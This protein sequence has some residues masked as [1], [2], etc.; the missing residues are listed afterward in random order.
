VQREIAA[1]LQR[2]SGAVDQASRERDRLRRRLDAELVAIDRR[3][4]GPRGWRTRRQLEEQLSEANETRKQ[5]EAVE[6][7]L[8]VAQRELSRLRAALLAAIDAELAAGP[9]AERAAELRARRAAHAPRVAA[10]RIV[11]PDLAIDRRLDPEELAE[12]AAAIRE[13]EEVL[14][15][16]IRGLAEQAR[17]LQRAAELR[18]QHERTLALDQ[19][20]DNASRRAA[21]GAGSPARGPEASVGQPGSPDASVS[22]ASGP[23]GRY[24]AEAPIV[25]PEVVG[26]AVIDGI[27][28]AQLSGDPARRAAAVLA[29]RDAVAEKQRQLR[30][31]RREIEKL[32]RQRP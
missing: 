6:A 21:S 23:G 9:A 14:E 19:R 3:K 8:A 13:S 7:R 22:G 10:R 26:P 2:A 25:L 5:L 28:Q 4:H 18:R 1:G 16:Q 30:Q 20:D 32:A 24:E 11:L 29:A 31:R 27:R 12:Q 17:E 15:R